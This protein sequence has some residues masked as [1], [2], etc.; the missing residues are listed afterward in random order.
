MAVADEP[1]Q[2]RAR[3]LRDRATAVAAG[4][5]RGLADLIVPP[6]CLVCRRP[7]GTHDALCAACWRTVSFIRQPLCDRMGLPLPYD[8]GGPTVSG[9]ALKH[10]PVYDRARAVGRFDRVMRELIHKLKYGDRHDARRLFGRWLKDAGAEI[11]TGADLLL[12]VPLHRWRLL[13]RRFNQAAIL[14]YEL[15][16]ETGIP[17]DPFLL[18]RVRATPSQVGLTPDER[19]RNLAGAF[20]VPA[21]ASKRIAGRNL[22]LIDDVI[23]T[24]A[25]VSAC[26]RV[27]KRAGAARVDVLALA[28]VTDDSRI[29]P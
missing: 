23:T 21:G 28:L 10:P 17:C 15:S 19:Q 6:V 1:E 20:A 13:R 16:R 24:G 2:L 29:F 27:L 22:V 26:A 4:A 14:A 3:D 7:L 12:P 25:T 9:A 11:L 8:T 18:T 5:A